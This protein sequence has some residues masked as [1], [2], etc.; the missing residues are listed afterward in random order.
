MVTKRHILFIV[1]NNPVPQDVR[2]WSEALAAKEAGYDVTVISP[3]TI[4]S[5]TAKH[6]IIEGIEIFRHPMPIEGS[7]LYGFAFEY[8]IALFYELLLCFRIYIKKPFSIIHG[9]NPPD[10]IFLIAC[11]F[12]LFG[13]KYIFD[14]HDLS[15][16]AYVA[17]FG[18]KNILYKILLLMEKAT[19]KTADIV[20]STNESYKM[21]AITRG[22]KNSNDV[23]VVRNGPT[24]S[25]ITFPEPNKKLKGEFD[26]LVAYL[27][28]I[29][30]QEGID[31]LLRSVRYIV[32]EKKIENIRFIIVGKGPHLSEMVKLSKEMMLEKYVT[33]TGYIPY[34][35]LYEILTTADLCVNSEFRNDFTDKS[36]MIKI[37]D[38]MTFGKPIVQFETS[39]GKVT[40]GESAFYVKNNDEV[41]FAEA[42]IE[43]LNDEPRRKK[44]GNIAKTR[45]DESLQ[46]N[47]QKDNLIKAYEY[48]ERK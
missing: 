30:N 15:P 36:T 22:N 31:N 17:K 8:L 38:Y 44:M 21:I 13:V 2:V 32:Y 5:N 40:A 9:A 10:H 33:F 14:H 20:I 23:F 24:L 41:D 26:Y 27:G 3:M 48:L 28:I 37:M 18:S 16:E 12:K 11:L 35:D 45:I 1:E 29:G 25:R 47:L 43:L 7:G 46:W 19:F 34:R 42:I 4:R 6:E 39:E